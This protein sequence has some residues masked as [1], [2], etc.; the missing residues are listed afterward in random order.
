MS[1][2]K[3]EQH[4]SQDLLRIITATHHDPFEVLGRHSLPVPTATADTLV[5][6]YLPGARSAE[7]VINRQ[8]RQIAPLNRLPGTDFFEWYGLGQQLPVHYQIEWYDRHNQHRVHYDPYAF[9]PQLGELDM[10]LFAEGQH[11]NIYN[12]LGA[13][14]RQVDG[15]NGVLFATWAPNAE[16]ISVVGNFNDWDG[17]H[18]PMRVRGSSGLWELFI[19]GVQPGD[20][21]KFEIRNRQTGAVFL[22]SDPYGQSFE[23]RPST[24]SI[25]T[26]DSAFA[27][28]DA[29]WME[30]RA[31]WDWQASPLSIYEVHLGSWR[32]GWAGEFLSYRELAHQLADYVKYM[33]FTHVEILPVS[34]HPLDDSWGYQTTGYYAPTSRF[35]SPDDF[36]YFVDHLHQQGI[37]IILDWVPAHFPKDAHALARFDG[38]ALYEHEDPRLG[39]HRDWGTLIYNYGRSEVRNF[40]LANA[41]FWLKEY[42]IDGLRV[43]AVAS[44]LHLDY[45]RQPGE[46]IPNIHGGNENLEAMTF[47]QQLNAICHG[48]HSGALVIAE[49]S[50]AWPQVTRP[51]WVGGLGFSMKWNMG[52]MHD[53]L[54]YMSREPVHRQYH[55]NQLTFGMMYA[56]TENFQL[57][58]S[59]DEVVHGK[60]SMINKMP[61]DDWQ[62]F[63]NLRLLYTYLYTYPGSKLLFMGGEFA[64]W[65]EWAHG[66]SLDWHLLDY[67][68]HQGVQSAVKDL[69]HLYRQ[70]PS[71]YQRNFRGDGFEWIDCHDSTQSIISY[72]RSSD[73]EFTLV[74]LN[75]TPVPRYN[76]RIGV[77]VAGQ[78]QEVF[79]SDSQF[80]GGSNLGNANPLY[81]QPVPWMNH[82]QSL[83]VTLPPLGGLLLKLA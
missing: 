53:T 61:G 28:Q 11:W 68:P 21:Y 8:N 7:L 39:E 60:G 50:T 9:A 20:L 32:R 5:R 49:E 35:G 31:H 41:L 13:H 66:R 40:L 23:H 54:E 22:K 3:Q 76:Y 14:P 51:T 79:N 34:E 16:R 77:P 44:M 71:L 67:G 73:S 63:A 24:S 74:I 64:Q 81:T 78:Y 42:H 58:F 6:V 2:P 45:S 27:W 59:H 25:I 75:F 18:H 52:W 15:I 12:L 47:L 46:W 36:R 37:G 30:H 69:N 82:G 1:N 55:H 38:S 48:Q 4:L 56:F 19:P 17:R 29:D 62:K 26:A 43:D 57:P 72:I 83:E 10:H 70:V 33:G 80:Y 65:S